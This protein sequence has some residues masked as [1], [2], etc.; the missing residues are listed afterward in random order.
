MIIQVEKIKDDGLSL[1]FEEG[2]EAFP[3]LADIA[4]AGECEFIAPFTTRLRAIRAHDMVEVEGEVSTRV[5]LCCSRCLDPFEAP[6][7]ASFA[8]TYTEELPQVADEEGAEE[9]EIDADE[10]GLILF[11]G[12]EIDLRQAVEEQVVLALPLRPLCREK[13]KGLCARC[14]ADLN[15]G[16]CGCD[17]SDFN[18]KFAALKDFKV[19]KKD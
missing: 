7:V 11:H 4:G 2:L 19:E 1:A 16:E 18:I 8:L 5:R 6:L 15:E 10:M 14:G 9:V 13:C 17:R 12:D 3:M